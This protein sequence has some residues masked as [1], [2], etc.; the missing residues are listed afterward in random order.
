M[1]FKHLSIFGEGLNYKLPISYGSSKEN[2]YSTYLNIM[3][4]EDLITN[5]LGN[6]RC[7]RRIRRAANECLKQ[8]L[9]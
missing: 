2:T 1:P 8:D 4:Q 5:A 9:Y 6:L 3:H 7:K